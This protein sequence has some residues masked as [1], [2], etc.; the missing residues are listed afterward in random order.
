MA[1]NQLMVLVA[2]IVIALSSLAVATH[3]LFSPSQRKFR[4]SYGLVGLTLLTG[5][6]LVWMHPAHLAQA[7]VSG[8]IYLSAVFAMMVAAHHRLARTHS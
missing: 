1:Y 4:M 5:I 8:L 3:L 2:H 6:T 7:C